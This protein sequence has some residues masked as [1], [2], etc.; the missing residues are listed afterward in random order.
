MRDEITSKFQRSKMENNIDKIREAWKQAID[1]DI[2]KAATIDYGEYSPTAQAVIEAE[3]KSRKLWEKVL[4]LRGQKTDESIPKE[5]NLAGYVCEGCK[6]THLNFETGRCMKCGLPSDRMGYCIECDNFWS[7]QPGQMC[8]SH[9]IKL[10]HHKAAMVMLRLGNLIF[11]TMIF[12]LLIYISVFSLVFLGLR[13]EYFTEIDPVD[14]LLIGVILWFFYDFIFEAIWQRTPAKFITGTKVV[15]STGAK[16]SV[17][18]ILIR[19][20]ARFVPFDAISFGGSRVRGWHDRWSGTYVIK[21]KRF[22]RKESGRQITAISPKDLRNTFVLDKRNP[23]EAKCVETGQVVMQLQQSS[24]IQ[25][26]NSIES[27]S[28]PRKNVEVCKN[29]EKTIGKLEKAFIL[30]KHIVCAECHQK[31]S[32]KL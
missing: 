18:T 3:A 22:E 13:P 8:P 30:K 5:G 15:T 16:P 10:S 26:D 31:L 25:V 20:L 24:I 4:Y 28:V 9:G 6:G 29:C 21:A 32:E 27:L 2:I 12:R 17:R 7:L 11:D 19:T 23:K 1:S 14:D